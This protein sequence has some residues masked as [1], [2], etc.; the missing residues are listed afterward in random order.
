MNMN[1][2]LFSPV[3]NGQKSQQCYEFEWERYLEFYQSVL[4]EEESCKL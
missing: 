1:T 2:M 3:H 4:E